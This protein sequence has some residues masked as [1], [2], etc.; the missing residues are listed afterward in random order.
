[1]KITWP[2]TKLL[3]DTDVMISTTV[4]NMSMKTATRAASLIP[5]RH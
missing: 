5:A 4:H 3:R 1:M 2:T